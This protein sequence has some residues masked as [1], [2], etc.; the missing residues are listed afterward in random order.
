M[1]GLIKAQE[2]ERVGSAW[3]PPLR[4]AHRSQLAALFHPPDAAVLTDELRVWQ[5]AAQ[6]PYRRG[7][8]D[9][10]ADRLYRRRRHVLDHAESDSI[11]LNPGGSGHSAIRH[12]LAETVQ[13]PRESVRRYSVAS[14]PWRVSQP[15]SGLPQ[16]LDRQPL[17]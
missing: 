12:K 13:P 10:C 1:G 3:L 17:D 2:E 6:S 7:H 16:E 15:A 5:S 9:W 4:L 8:Q 14:L 11:G